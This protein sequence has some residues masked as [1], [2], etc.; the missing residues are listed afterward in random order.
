MGVALGAVTVVVVGLMVGNEV[1]VAIV[2]AALRRLADAAHVPVAV[3]LARV[4]G[5][6]MP[7]WYAGTL[8]LTIGVVVVVPWGVGSWVVIGAAVLFAATIVLA[9]VVLA[10]LNNR[11]AAWDVESLPPDWLKERRQW[12]RLHLLRVVL[13]IAGWVALV[14]GVLMLCR[15]D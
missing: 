11:V 3:A 8:L 5:R 13:L 2:H 6:L 10:P 12:D 7:F 9:A 15:G 4:Y 1:A 14:A